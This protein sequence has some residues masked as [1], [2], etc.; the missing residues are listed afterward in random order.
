MK[1]VFLILT[2]VPLPHLVVRSA[3]HMYQLNKY[4]VRFGD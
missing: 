3:V 2:K 4:L 1:A